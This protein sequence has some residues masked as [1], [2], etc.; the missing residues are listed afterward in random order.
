[1]RKAL[2]TDGVEVLLDFRDNK[3]CKMAI[4]KDSEGNGLMLHEIAPER[5]KS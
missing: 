4:I 3:V 1:M 5:A 2:E